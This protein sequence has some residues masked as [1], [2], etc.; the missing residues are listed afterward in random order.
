MSNLR[1]AA[2]WGLQTA[3]I[4][5]LLLLLWRPAISVATLRPQQNIVA[6]LLDSSRSMATP[7]LP[8]CKP[9]GSSRGR[10][11]SKPR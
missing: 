8:I 10:S 2:I 7:L 6:V 4:A 11:T 1:A 9:W 3:L 5:L